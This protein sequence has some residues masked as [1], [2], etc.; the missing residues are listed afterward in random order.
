MS[1]LTSIGSPL[2][3]K[4]NAPVSLFICSC[5]KRT[6]TLYVLVESEESDPGN[7][8]ISEFIKF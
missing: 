5:R 4:V 6:V 8:S 2:K 3:V 1:Y 7:A